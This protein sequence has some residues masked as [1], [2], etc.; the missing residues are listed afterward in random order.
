LDKQKKIFESFTQADG[1]T[2][3]KYGGTGLGLTVSAK[4]AELLG[5]ELN[6]T[7]Q[8]GVGSEFIFSAP[9]VLGQ[10]NDETGEVRVE[11]SKNL[12]GHTL[13]VEDNEANQ[14]FIGIIL[15][16]AGLTYD[17][18]NNG[19]EAVEMFKTE[20]YKVI[21]MDENMPKLNGIGAT[22]KILQIEAEQ[23][24]AHTPI[25]ALTANALVGDRQHFL[26]AGMDDYLAKPL[27]PVQLIEK[28]KEL[29]G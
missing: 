25:I 2:V 13:L 24:L 21:L 27:E 10:H 22:K 8:E 29:I 4:L 3:R 5:G 26:N 23:G 9:F 19:V 11:K 20:K 14:M 12:T 18:A 7:S 28:I 17:T 6:V 1:S 15:R 16:N